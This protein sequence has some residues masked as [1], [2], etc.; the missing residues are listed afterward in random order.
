M[1]DSPVLRL[2][3]WYRVFLLVFGR[4]LAALSLDNTE[5]WARQGEV[6]MSNEETLSGQRAAEPGAG[7][8]SETAGKGEAVTVEAQQYKDLQAKYESE[9]T[10]R[11]EAENTLELVQP[12]IDF[13]AVNSGG[14]KNS[15]SGN[16]E[17]GETASDQYVS[18]KEVQ[19]QLNMVEQRNNSKI[20][21][22]Q[23]RVNHPDLTE[24]EKTLV[25]PAVTRLR[26]QHP[27]WTGEKVIEEAAKGTRAF[28]KAEHE[29]AIALSK[30]KTDDDKQ[31]AAAATGFSSTGSTSPKKTDDSDSESYDVYMAR[32]K[33]QSARSRGLI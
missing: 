26:Q 29:K 32:R 2:D 11:E 4:L 3:V 19:K 17:E 7:Q 18:K 5:D 21:A 8:D 30:S 20:L 25:I 12:Y 10:A 27:T 28:L 16:I 24:Y 23:F 9:K 1:E 22:M 33:E 31:K 6:K 14:E 15:G 13:D